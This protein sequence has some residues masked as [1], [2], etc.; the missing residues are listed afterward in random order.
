MYKGA[1]YL[2]KNILFPKLISIKQSLF[3]Y[4]IIFALGSVFLF[5]ITSRIDEML[6]REGVFD[7]SIIDPL[8]FS[9]GA[10]A[11][12]SILSAISAGWA[13]ILGVAFS[14]TLITLQ[15][16]TSRYT[17]HIVNKFENDKL[18]QLM[19]AWFISVVLY[20]LLVLKTVRSGEEQPDIFTPIVGVNIAVL[21]AAIA[22]FIFIAFLH[23]IASY[24]RPNALISSI[25]DQIIQSIKPFETRRKYYDKRYDKSLHIDKKLFQQKIIFELKANKNGICSGID[26][27]NIYHILQEFSKQNKTSLYMQWYKTLG[28]SIEKDDLIALI[29]TNE[30]KENLKKETESPNTHINNGNNSNKNKSKSKFDQQFN[31]NITISKDRSLEDPAYGIE[32]LRSLSVKSIK[33]LD[34]DVI[35]SCTTGLFRILRYIFNSSEYLG[36]MFTFEDEVDDRPSDNTDKPFD[37]TAAAKPNTTRVIINPKESKL[38]D[39]IFFE[40]S[41]TLE[42]ATSDNQIT[43]AK[44]FVKEYVSLSRFLIESRRINEFE[45]LTGWLI[46]QI[47]ISITS[48][49]KQFQAQLIIDLLYFKEEL[50]INHAELLYIFDNQIQRIITGEIKSYL[51]TS[52]GR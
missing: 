8:I 16:S 37:N 40:L 33:L 1:D 7:L 26:W 28:D 22:L 43:V 48:F 14:V 17:S 3:F 6:Y 31:S 15:L 10:E 39:S 36:I 49:Q 13:T 24:L 2:F 46:D 42:S 12:R 29:Y 19:L 45:R 23:N 47:S 20:S 11:S 35:N 5:L 4:P 30:R 27:E 21:L 50:I 51:N 44:H 38:S 41:F 52:I 34:I 18:N 9:G 25:V 32:L